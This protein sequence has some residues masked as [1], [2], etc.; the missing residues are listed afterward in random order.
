MW[1]FHTCMHTHGTL[2]PAQALLLHLCCLTCRSHCGLSLMLS[3]S[4]HVVLRAW[5]AM[6]PVC[7]HAHT[8]IPTLNSR[9]PSLAQP[10]AAE[11]Q[12]C[13]DVGV[14]SRGDC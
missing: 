14:G 8:C 10:D 4:G 3:G 6:Q 11:E 2:A 9:E 5:G 12:A 1:C 7:A 13:G